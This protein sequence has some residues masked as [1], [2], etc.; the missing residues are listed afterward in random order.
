MVDHSYK[1]V[2]FLELYCGKIYI[3]TENVEDINPLIPS[4]AIKQKEYELF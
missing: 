1:N 4:E 3:I 2:T